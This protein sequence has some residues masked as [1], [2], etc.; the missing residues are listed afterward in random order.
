MLRFT[1]QNISCPAQLALE[2]CYI[3]TGIRVIQRK[4]FGYE[5]GQETGVGWAR[6]RS[7]GCCGVQGF[8]FDDRV[9]ALILGV[10]KYTANEISIAVEWVR[11]YVEP[12]GGNCQTRRGD[13]PAYAERSRGTS[14]TKPPPI[15]AMGLTFPT[16]SATATPLATDRYRYFVCCIISGN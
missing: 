8:E 2:S 12:W 15:G 10:D 7:S 1:I 5:C 11:C 9:D 3:S 13:W 16:P 4:S 6:V 14:W